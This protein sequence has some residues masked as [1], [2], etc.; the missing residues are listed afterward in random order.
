MSDI[1]SFVEYEI[2]S[3]INYVERCNVL[4]KALDLSFWPEGYMHLEKKASWCLL[5]SVFRIPISK[6]FLSK[7]EMEHYGDAVIQMIN[8]SLYSYDNLKEDP[9]DG[10]TPEDYK[11]YGG[12]HAEL[13]KTAKERIKSDI[14]VSY[15]EYTTYDLRRTWMHL[16]FNMGKNYNEYDDPKSMREA[17]HQ[18]DRRLTLEN[19]QIP[20]PA[21]SPSSAPTIIDAEHIKKFARAYNDSSLGI[22]EEGRNN[23][24]KQT[25][26]MCQV[27]LKRKDFDKSEIADRYC[28]ID[29]EKED[30]LN[31]TNP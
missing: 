3:P 23:F 25:N 5:E 16:R 15:D 12:A 26:K 14:Q 18:I 6:S 4:A 11:N 9:F 19:I 29:K 1:S 8:Y 7:D 24:L 22:N 28:F 30:L 27:L 10:M 21:G 13:I 31:S 17:Y 2:K 20:L